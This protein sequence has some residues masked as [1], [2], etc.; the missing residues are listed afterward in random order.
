MT[1]HQLEDL[2]NPAVDVKNTTGPAGAPD[3][4][5]P[6]SGILGSIL[7]EAPAAQKA[8]IEEATKGAND[9]TGM[10]RHKKPRQNAPAAGGEPN[11]SVN[12]EGKRKADAD[13]DEENK[14]K[15]ARTEELTDP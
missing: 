9:L 5:N 6:L 10:V 8:R 13:A 2:R 12:G 7:G 11:S 4:S 15:R 3:G 14:E 1:V